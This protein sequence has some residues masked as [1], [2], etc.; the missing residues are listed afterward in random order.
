MKKVPSYREKFYFFLAATQRHYKS[1]GPLP[2]TIKSLKFPQQCRQFKHTPQV[3]FGMS[4]FPV[5]SDPENPSALWES[6][7]FGLSILCRFC[8]LIS[9]SNSGRLS[10]LSSDLP[11]S[12]NAFR[13][14]VMSILPWVPDS[15]HCW[16]SIFVLS[17]QHFDDLQKIHCIFYPDFSLFSMV[18][19][20]HYQKENVLGSC[21]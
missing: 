18:I 2:P 11:D 16:I 21:F 19:T 3:L 9:V 10:K 20:C 4:Q 12:E 14:K 13:A 17:D 5:L 1:R 6:S 8:A 15:F 7:S